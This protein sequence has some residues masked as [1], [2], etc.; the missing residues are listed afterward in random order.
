VLLTDDL[1]PAARDT[2][3]ATGLPWIIENVPEA[4]LRPDYLLCGSMFGLNIR[5]DGR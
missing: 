2:L 1:I 5:R 4:G 3:T